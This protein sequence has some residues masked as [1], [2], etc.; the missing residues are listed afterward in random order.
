MN[1]CE[2]NHIKVAYKGQYKKVIPKR[3][4]Y[5]S[6]LHSVLLTE[7]LKA[8]EAFSGNFFFYYFICD[9]SRNSIS[10]LQYFSKIICAE[11]LQFSGAISR[12]FSYI[13]FIRDFIRKRIR[14]I[15]NIS[16]YRFLFRYGFYEGGS[17]GETKHA[18]AT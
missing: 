7:A 8:A 5:I 12:N 16:K 6:Q 4:H 13:L 2:S 3:L 18:N 17:T 9:F 15:Q 10:I 1:I 11:L 14:N